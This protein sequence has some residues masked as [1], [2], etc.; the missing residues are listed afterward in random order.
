[1]T[2]SVT[3]QAPAGYAEAVTEL[4]TILSEIERADV[5]VDLLATKVSRANVLIEFCRSRITAAQEAVDAVAE[6]EPP[7]L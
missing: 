3:D 2:D 5:D 7:D 6:E 4:E 1:M